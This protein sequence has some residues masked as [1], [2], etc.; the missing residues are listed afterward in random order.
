MRLMEVVGVAILMAELALI[1]RK[2]SDPA[3]DKSFDRRS[4]RT[5]WAACLT[6]VVAA[7]ATWRLGLGPR[8]ELGLVWQRTVPH[9]PP[10]TNL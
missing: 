10:C 2:Q 9:G 5:M 4:F 7:F 1:A 8:F 3:R 6:G